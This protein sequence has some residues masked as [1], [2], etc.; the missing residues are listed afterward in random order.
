VDGGVEQPFAPALG[1]FAIAGVLW[2]VRDHTGIENALAIVRGVKAAIEVDIGAFQVQSDLF[3]HLLQGVQALGKEHHIC[4]IHR[5]HVDGRYDVAMIVRDRNDFLPLLV[6]VARVPDAI[7]PFLATV[8]V[9]SPWRMLASNS[10]A[11]NCPGIGVVAGF[12]AGMLI[13]G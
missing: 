3:G 8:L 13:R 7:A 12:G 1:V 6:F 2:D 4:L 11:D 9:T 5:G 10:S